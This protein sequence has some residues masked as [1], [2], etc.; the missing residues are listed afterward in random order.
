MYNFSSP[1]ADKELGARVRSFV[2]SI[3]P[4]EKD[5]RNTSHGPTDELR[6]ELNTMAREAGLLAPQVASPYGGKALSHVQRAI[7][8]EAA[9]YS[10]LGPIALHCAAPDE[11]NMHLLEVVASEAQKEKYLRPLATAKVRSCFAMT[12]PAPG[13]GSDPSLLQTV[14]AGDGNTFRVSGRKWLITGADGA[15]FMILMARTL[16]DGKDEGATMFMVDLPNPAVKIVRLIDSID[17]SF[18]QGH[19]VVDIDDLVVSRDDVLGEIGGGF[20]YAQVRLAPA[21][22]T[23]CMRWIGAAQRAHDIAVEHARTRPAFG[24]PIG[25]H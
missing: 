1:Q 21:R 14:A 6:I 11:G 17:S 8:F 19:A 2:E 25:Q 9:G 12:E 5:P 20:R 16:V 22:L 23:H 10:P 3:I 15:A 4:Y 24:K 7:V 18:T 13:A